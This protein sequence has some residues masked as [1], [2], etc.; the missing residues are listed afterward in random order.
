MLREN[1]LRFSQ[2]YLKV[3]SGNFHFQQDPNNPQIWIIT[4]DP[5]AA[6]PSSR[7]ANHSNNQSARM[8]GGSESSNMMPRDYKMVM[9]DVMLLLFSQV[10][11]ITVLVI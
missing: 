8:P 4:N 3:V 5:A 11:D 2:E 7:H 9:D 10:L 1:E 6:A